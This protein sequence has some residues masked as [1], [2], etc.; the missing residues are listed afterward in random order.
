MLKWYFLNPLILAGLLAQSTEVFTVLP[1]LLALLAATRGRT[2]ASTL[3]LAAAVNHDVF[4]LPLLV[5]VALLLRQHSERRTAV[6]L[7]AFAGWSSLVALA[8]FQLYS[9][10]AWA[11]AR[12]GTMWVV[13]RH[14]GIVVY[15]FCHLF[16]SNSA[17]S[18]IVVMYCNKIIRVVLLCSVAQV[19]VGRRGAQRWTALVPFC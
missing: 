12:H 14:V 13:L 7:L 9:S 17:G 5:P 19:Y 15:G 8:S 3:C 2:A 4:I 6:V 16:S 11:W 10:W 18:S 1:L